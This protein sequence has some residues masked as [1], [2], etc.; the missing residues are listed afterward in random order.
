MEYTN[1]Y[2]RE[3][4]LVQGNV[5][6]NDVI[7]GMLVRIRTNAGQPIDTLTVPAVFASTD[8]TYVITENL[9]IVGQVGGP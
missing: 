5:V 8:I 2:D 3:G 6:A 4:P 9:Y 1:D 7:N